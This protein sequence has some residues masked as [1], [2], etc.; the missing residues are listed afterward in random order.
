M[1]RGVGVAQKFL[2]D[3]FLVAF[4]YTKEK[5][6]SKQAEDFSG[7]FCTAREKQPQ[8]CHFNRNYFDLNA[9]FHEPSHRPLAGTIARFFYQEM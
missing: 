4:I 3:C 2:Q 6:H 9:P 8:P 1:N 5:V 7:Q